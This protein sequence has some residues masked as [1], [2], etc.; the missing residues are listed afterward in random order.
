MNDKNNFLQPFLMI[1]LVIMAFF[2]GILW[3]KLKEAKSINK[4]SQPEKQAQNNNKFQ[5]KKSKKP[6]DKNV[7]LN[8]IFENEIEIF[9]KDRNKYLDI[10]DIETLEEY[11]TDPSYFKDTVL[12]NQCPIIQHTLQNKQAKELDKY[13]RQNP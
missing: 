3:M 6:I 12:R 8:R 10:L 9:E 13:R 5:A 2:S 1:L 11:K 7:K 4:N